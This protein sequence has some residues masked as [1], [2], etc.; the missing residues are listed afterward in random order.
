ML[1]LLPLLYCFFYFPGNGSCLGCDFCIRH[2][3]N[4]GVKRM[5]LQNGLV[6]EGMHVVSAHRRTR[7]R[8][9][10]DLV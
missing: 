8:S 3:C 6:H 10:R 2:S 7:V 4:D 9:A 5:A 1:G